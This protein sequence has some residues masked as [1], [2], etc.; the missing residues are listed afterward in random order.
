[1]KE[2]IRKEEKKI[3]KCPARKVSMCFELLVG[4][5]LTKFLHLFASHHFDGTLRNPLDD[6]FQIDLVDELKKA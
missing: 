4:Q 1:M 2:I 5:P 6:K 3:D